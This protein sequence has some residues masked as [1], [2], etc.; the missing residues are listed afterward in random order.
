[1]QPS[2]WDGQIVAFTKYKSIKRGDIILFKHEGKNVVKRVIGLPNEKV[3]ISD[4]CYIN[5]QPIERPMHVF[6]LEYDWELQ[7]DEYIVLGDNLGDSL[8]SRKLGKIKTS[9][10]THKY[11]M[12]I[13]PC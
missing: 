1:M 7:D 10:I 3:V 4:Q 6:P 9:Q 11:L 5:D 2:L 12:K 13:P 8:D